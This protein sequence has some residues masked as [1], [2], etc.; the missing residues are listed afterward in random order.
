MAPLKIGLLGYGGIARSVHAPALGRHPR[1]EI[2]AVAEADPGRRDL[3]RRELPGTSLFDS[4]KDLLNAGEAGAVLVCLPNALH[5]EAAT[6]A[7]AAVLHVYVEKP[8][9]TGIEEAAALA[10]RSLAP[11]QVA[12]VGFNYR[13]HPFY[14]EARQCIRAG[15]LGQVVTVRSCFSTAPREL[16][17]WKLRR[18]SGGGVLLDLASHHIDLL[19]FLLDEEVVEVSA[20]LASRRSEDDTAWVQCWLAGGLV[21]QSFFSFAAIDE[22][23]FEICGDRGKLIA[24]RLRGWSLETMPATAD[25]S[26]IS[27]AAVGFARRV[28]WPLTAV[29]APAVRARQRDFLR[30][31]SGAF[32]RHRPLR[33][34]REPRLGRWPPISPDHRCR[35]AIRPV[36]QTRR[37]WQ[38]GAV[39]ILLVND[40][41]TPTGGAEIAMLQVR[42]GLRRRGHDA[43]LFS[44]RAQD[45][46]P[47]VARLAD[48]ECHGTTGP[49][50][51]LLETANPWAAHRL[52][53]VLREFQPDVVH[54]KVFL[55]QLSPLI[56]PVLR[57]VPSLY[58]VAWSRSV[59]PLGTKLLPDGGECREAP[60]AVCYSKG[61]LP[62]RDFFPL[63]IQLRLLRRWLGCF[64]KI[65]ANS[66][67]TRRRLRDGGIEPVEVCYYG[68]PLAPPRPPL[69]E[70]PT[71]AFAG[72]L[73]PAKG[74][75]VL[76]RAFAKLL[77]SLPKARLQI[78]GDGPERDPL[79]RL[80]GSLGIDTSVEFL[81][82][83]SL[84][85]LDRR[86][87][88]AWVQI[89]PSRW[90]EP[91]GLVA[92]EAF[93]RG[94][95][96]VAT[97][98]GG[99][100]EIVRDGETGS[101]VPP[102]DADALAAAMRNV[103]DDR[104]R[105]ERMGQAARNVA[106]DRFSEEAYIDRLLVMYDE[107]QRRDSRRPGGPQA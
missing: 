44:S 9:A 107:L 48:Y 85:E 52:R 6:A 3:C 23:R 15:A 36:Q 4:W 53:A 105:A 29:A 38:A 106:R 59:C 84:A 5:A 103:L 39:K 98:A 19:R 2:A 72:R 56:L 104:T 34:S 31:R 60:G 68:V 82:H 75:D 63:M 21:A 87:A 88:P 32:R 26:R 27:G 61:C 79:Q 101:L 70:P 25:H 24:D 94:T 1:A 64:S 40:Y 71:A 14:A 100:A 83:L 80:A 11:G 69:V 35:R 46:P 49:G 42:E 81:G 73:V 97:G 62:L 12:M 96:V 92:I 10:A 57:P 55:T 8:L 102:G 66:E 18:N 76:L 33:S 78:A 45:A 17:D 43:R 7:L 41:S 30:P 22:D 86:F 47:S 67:A 51:T 50:R 89:V 77:V 93:A 54:V 13:F 95:A 74:V 99:L 28:G 20:R 58:Q 65:V 91:F 16:P 37:D 90:E